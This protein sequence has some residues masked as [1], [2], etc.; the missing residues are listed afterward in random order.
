M[1][2]SDWLAGSD[3]PVRK[4]DLDPKK[5]PAEKLVVFPEKPVSERPETKKPAHPVKEANGVHGHSNGK[6][7]SSANKESDNVSRIKK[8]GGAPSQTPHGLA[9]T[10][11]RKYEARLEVSGSDEPFT[12]WNLM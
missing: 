10:F 9:P 12:L 5:R 4:I 3:V 7:P 11:P 1:G 2:P 6:V 8:S